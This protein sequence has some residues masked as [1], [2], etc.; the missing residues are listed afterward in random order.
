MPENNKWQMPAEEK[1]LDQWVL[2]TIAPVLI[3]IY[4]IIE[5]VLTALMELE[6]HV[7]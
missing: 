4:E 6:N 5:Q 1:S 2:D 7:N 3:V